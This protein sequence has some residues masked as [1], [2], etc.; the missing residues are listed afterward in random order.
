MSTKLSQ[1]QDILR[2]AT[3]MEVSEFVRH[4]D[5]HL[6]LHELSAAIGTDR[7]VPTYEVVMYQTDHTKPYSLIQAIKH[8][9]Q[10]LGY[11]MKEAKDYVDMARS[12]S[13]HPEIVLSAFPYTY[14]TD[15]ASLRSHMINYDNCSVGRTGFDVIV[16][17]I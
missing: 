16:R 7:K 8:V 12:R 3:I 2:S 17:E 1:I 13:T 14:Q 9:R 4:F 10:A 6:S 11:S 15:A 5:V